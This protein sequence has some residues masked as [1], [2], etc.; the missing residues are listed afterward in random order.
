MGVR[1]WGLDI[2]ANAGTDSF[3]MPTA[4]EYMRKAEEC[5]AS[6]GGA[7]DPAE[8]AML[9]QLYEQWLRL[10]HYKRGKASRQGPESSN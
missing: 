4:D 2:A 10:A 7:Q 3:S 5:L 1:T 9:M 8:P 6:A